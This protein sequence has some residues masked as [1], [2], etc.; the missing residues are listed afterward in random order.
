[1]VP[2]RGLVLAVSIAWLVGSTPA[3]ASADNGATLTVPAQVQ[4]SANT[5]PVV[6]PSFSYPEPTPFC[7]VG[8]DFTWDSSAWLSEFPT[9]NGSLCVAGGI[10]AS[11]P[12]EHGSPGS[13][14][15]CASAGPRYTDCKTV[16]VVLAAG[17]AAPATPGPGG[18]APAPAPTQAAQV[19][20]P[21]QIPSDAPAPRAVTAAVN[22][23]SPTQRLI[24]LTLLA[25]GVLG[26][27][28][29]VGRRVVLSRRRKPLALPSPD[30]PRRRS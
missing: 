26:L 6:Q 27:L 10:N 22:S 30:A 28:G 23:L 18:A 24:G 12:A 15:V 7:T 11:A 20:Q 17:S 5:A 2:H 13:H 14:R 16:V 19:A 1:M 4:T 8:V 29:I 3:V 21:L 9:K 25:V